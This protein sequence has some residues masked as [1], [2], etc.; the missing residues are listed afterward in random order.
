MRTVAICQGAPARQ[1]PEMRFGWFEARRRRLPGQFRLEM[2]R[3]AQAPALTDCIVGGLGRRARRVRIVVQTAA[4]DVELAGGRDIRTASGN[5]NV[6][7]PVSTCRYSTRAVQFGAKAH[8]NAGARGPSDA[9]VVVAFDRPGVPVQ[10]GQLGPRQLA[11]GP[12]ETASAV[13]QP[14]VR[15][16]TGA[17]AGRSEV[18]KLAVELVDAGRADHRARQAGP[19]RIDLNAAEPVGSPHVVPADLA[20]GGD[21]AD[22]RRVGAEHDAAR[23]VV[24]SSLCRQMPPTLAPT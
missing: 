21:I 23:L 5:D 20:A 16:I 3:P 17:E 24:V 4:N 9:V 18:I 6:S 22:A 8:F 15:H 12:R 2:Q 11:V 7:V 1:S 14:V 13:E 10:S 19:L